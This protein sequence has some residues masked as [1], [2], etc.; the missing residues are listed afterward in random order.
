LITG[1]VSTDYLV[2]LVGQ[3][4][5]GT[6]L[7]VS[8]GFNAAKAVDM[9]AQGRGWDALRALADTFVAVHGANKVGGALVVAAVATAAAISDSATPNTEPPDGPPDAYVGGLKRWK[10]TAG[11]KSR[12][13]TPKIRQEIADWTKNRGTIDGPPTNEPV[14]AGHTY[15]R[16]H[17]F[18]PAGEE[19]EVAAQTAK[20]N[21]SQAPDEAR[22]AARRRAHNEANLVGP[23]LPV[24]PK[25]K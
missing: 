12:G 8:S 15:G 25:S 4:A 9:V 17:V 23:Q 1:E 2:P 16:S 3:L 5:A 20:G 19:T 10:I 18:T 24:R 11:D 7:A 6:D 13:I 14:H 22:A 21:L